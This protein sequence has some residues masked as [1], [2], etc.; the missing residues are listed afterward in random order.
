M[1]HIVRPIWNVPYS[2][3]PFFTGREEILTRLH[4]FL[5][6]DNTAALI[7]PQGISGLGGIGKTQTALEY[8]YH[9]SNDYQAVLW[10]RADSQSTL[11]SE[12]VNL[13]YLLQLPE[14]EE[15]DQNLIVEAVMRW[16]RATS[17][18]LLIL[19]N[20]EDFTVATPFIPLAGRGH[21]LLTTRAHALGGIAQRIELEKMQPEVGSLLLLRRAGFLPP[22]SLLD[23]AHEQDRTHAMEISRLVDGLPLALDQ[24]GAYIKE[25]ACSL[26]DYLALYHIRS[27]E[28]LKER[29]SIYADYPHSVAATWSLSFEKVTQA[30]PAAAELLFLCAFLYPDAIPEEIITDA[31]PD[32]GPILEPVAAHPLQVDSALKEVLR[33]SF[34]QREP[35]TRTFTIH[36]LVQAVLKDRM[37]QSLQHL[38]AERA[39]R[40]VNDTFPLVDF[41]VWPRCQRCI[42]HAQ[43]CATLI[44]QWD[45]IFPVAVRLLSVAGDYL[46]ERGR[47]KEA[48]PL[49]LQM[50]AVCE[51]VLEPDHPEMAMFLN[52]VA[53]LYDAQGRYDQA[54]MLYQ[55][56]L[57]IAE[58]TFGPG[59]PNMAIGLNNLAALYK[60]LGKYEQAEALHLRSLAIKEAAFGPDHLELAV[61]LNNLAVI[62][63]CMHKYDLAEAYYQRSLAIKEAALGL[64]H[65][66]VATNLNNLAAL[67][68]KQENY[69]QARQL[70]QRALATREK[71]L[72]PDH[73]EVAGNLN[74]LAVLCEA[75]GESEQAELL[76]QR[77]LRIDEGTF[78]LE[79]PQVATDLNNLATLYENRGQHDQ[80][81]PLFQRSLAIKEKILDAE[82]PSLAASLNNLAFCYRKQ[83][84]YDQAE[85]LYRRSLTIREKTL[86][87]AHPETA[88]S[89][90]NLAVLYMDQGRFESAEPL[91]KRALAIR[92]EALGPNHPDTV[93]CL[94]NLM[95]SALFKTIYTGHSRGQ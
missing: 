51:R 47:Y 52:D 62:Y 31:A 26:S 40:A 60:N 92:K 59:H 50:L 38:W 3:N 53:L 29:G 56:S 1:D 36:R 9:Y 69:E 94:K 16:L 48:E 73:P 17:H 42:L 75:V 2:R 20:I 89:L 63:E 15:Q 18:W 66:S 45:M 41:E 28:L 30:N 68:K 91:L 70:Y 93:A 35:D 24:A 76:Y 55:R 49:L 44:E 83:G 74:N 32:L 64:E 27:T 23:A 79:H 86:G 71:V 46:Y 33:F 12:F 5:Q 95:L 90:N 58:N 80:S 21:I 14:K 57:G 81:E 37:S 84:E 4:D 61:S 8:A 25:M 7:Q 13:A 87:P 82:H 34:L 43:T 65:P 77:A 72:G 78:G 10:V 6:V 39:V 19:D 22:E 88:T 11:I 85:P 54:E 67:Y